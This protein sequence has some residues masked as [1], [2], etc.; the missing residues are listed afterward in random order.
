MRHAAHMHEVQ[1]LSRVLCPLLVAISYDRW[2]TQLAVFAAGV[3]RAKGPDPVHRQ[4]EGPDLGPV[5][6]TQ[7]AAPVRKVV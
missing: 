5:A 4:P 3:L 1:S 6:A 7:V 2:N